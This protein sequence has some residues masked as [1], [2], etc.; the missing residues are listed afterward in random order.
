LTLLSS[1]PV[2]TPTGKRSSSC[3]ARTA[4]WRGAGRT[5]WTP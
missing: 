2:R 4:H 5:T 1:T 3:G